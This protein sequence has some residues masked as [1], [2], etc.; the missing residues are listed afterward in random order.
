VNTR[1]HQNLMIFATRCYA[2]TAYAVVRCPIHVSVCLSRSWALS[3]RINVC[4]NFFTVVEP[5]YS[6]FSTPNVMAILRVMTGT[7]LTGA[8]NAGGVGNSQTIS[9]SMTFC[10]RS[11]RL[12]SAVHSAATN[13]GKLLTLSRLFLIGDDD[14]VFMTRSQSTLR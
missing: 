8:S 13:R 7:H 1:F 3:K 6:N 9:G 2:S 5:H 12:T 11:V 4:S 14:E 10:E